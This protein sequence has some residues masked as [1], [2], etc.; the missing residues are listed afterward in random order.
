MGEDGLNAPRP[1]SKSYEFFFAAE[2]SKTSTKGEDPFSHREGVIFVLRKEIESRGHE[3]P[4][5]STD[6][7]TRFAVDSLSVRR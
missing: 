2:A 1:A 4:Q 6:D 5:D 3:G 7:L